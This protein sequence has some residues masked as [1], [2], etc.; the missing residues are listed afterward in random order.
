[1]G[2]GPVLSPLARGLPPTMDEILTMEKQKVAHGMRFSLELAPMSPRNRFSL[3]HQT[4]A[5][6][7][8]VLDGM[9]MAAHSHHL[10]CCCLSVHLPS[11][12]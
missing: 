8:A 4:D 12:Y 10:A 2:V 9:C 7:D 6:L 11:C 1:M 5:S 3:T